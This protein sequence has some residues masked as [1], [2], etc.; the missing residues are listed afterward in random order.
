MADIDVE[1]KRPALWAFVVGAVVLGLLIWGL[2]SLLD[3]DENVHIDNPAPASQTAPA[4]QP[5]GP[6]Q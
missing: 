2:I 3:R 1:R 4:A 5:A 6:G